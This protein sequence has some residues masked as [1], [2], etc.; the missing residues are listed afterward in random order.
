MRQ[1]EIFRKGILGVY[2]QK[3]EVS[4]TSAM[5]KRT[6]RVKERNP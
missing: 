4:I 1:A 6:F 5:T 3:M 2:S